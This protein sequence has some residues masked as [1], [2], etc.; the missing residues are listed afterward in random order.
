MENETLKLKITKILIFDFSLLL[1]H[2]PI[3]IKRIIINKRL[4]K[5]SDY[6]DGIAWRQY[7]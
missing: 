6:H 7:G 2:A 5:K 1:Y 3:L 4:Y